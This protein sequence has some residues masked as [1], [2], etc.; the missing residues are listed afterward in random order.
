MPI[1]DLDDAMP[2][3]ATMNS[4]DQ[5]DDKYLKSIVASARMMINGD[6]NIPRH[7]MDARLTKQLYVSTVHSPSAQSSLSPLQ[8]KGARGGVPSKMVKAV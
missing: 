6:M 5:I 2:A 7:A 3:F 1:R 4:P 8:A